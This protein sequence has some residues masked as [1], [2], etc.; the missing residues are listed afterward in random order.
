MDLITE[1]RRHADEC[2]RMSRATVNVD[3]SASW[4]RMA[5]RWSR[6]AEVAEQE[7]RA[8]AGARTERERH[9]GPRLAGRPQQAA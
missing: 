2:R 6:C 1:F 8:L 9:R 5:E 3:D 7:E 4:T